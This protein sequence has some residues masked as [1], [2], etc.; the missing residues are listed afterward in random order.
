MSDRWMHTIAYVLLVLTYIS[1]L[2]IG[3]AGISKKYPKMTYIVY[4]IVATIYLV[5]AVYA[6]RHTSHQNE[7]DSETLA[8]MTEK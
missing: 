5:L 2:V 1:L 8:C 3:V 4:G 6:Y 7:I